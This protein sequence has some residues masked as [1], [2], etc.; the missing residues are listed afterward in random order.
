MSEGFPS[1]FRFFFFFYFAFFT[2][3][4]SSKKTFFHIFFVFPYPGALP[5]TSLIPL[6]TK[7]YGAILGDRKKEE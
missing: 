1:V 5:E 7:F 4:I 6:K 2:F 3:F